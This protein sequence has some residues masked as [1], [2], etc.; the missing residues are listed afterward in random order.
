[1]AEVEAHA[2]LRAD[3]QA[4]VV[5]G[6]RDVHEVSKPDDIFLTEPEVAPEFQIRKRLERRDPLTIGPDMGLLLLHQQLILVLGCHT[7]F[8]FT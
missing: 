2:E 5:T 3:R 8:G 4:S 7:T 1:M 6:P